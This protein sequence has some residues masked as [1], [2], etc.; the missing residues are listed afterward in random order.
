[1]V[2]EDTMNNPIDLDGFHIR[3]FLETNIQIRK[4]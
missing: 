4:S 3:N 1:M 2:E